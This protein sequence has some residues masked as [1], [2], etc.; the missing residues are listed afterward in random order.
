M[1]WCCCRYASLG[2]RVRGTSENSD[3]AASSSRLSAPRHLRNQRLG[4]VNKC[5]KQRR[6]TRQNILAKRHFTL[7]TGQKVLRGRIQHLATRWMDTPVMWGLHCFFISC[8]RCWANSNLLLNYEPSQ[9]CQHYGGVSPDWLYT[10]SWHTNSTQGV[11][12]HCPSWID[13][14]M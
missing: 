1:W 12:I 8:N 14:N 4:S 9:P 11:N 7:R 5:A 3:T 2:K 13:T 10:W 6:G